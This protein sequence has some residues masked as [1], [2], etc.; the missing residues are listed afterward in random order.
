M[1]ETHNKLIETNELVN[2]KFAMRDMLF[3]IGKGIRYLQY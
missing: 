2:H 3:L 1:K